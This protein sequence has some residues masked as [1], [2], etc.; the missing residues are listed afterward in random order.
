MLLLAKILKSLINKNYVFYLLS[1]YFSTL[2]ELI[3][4]FNFNPINT[5]E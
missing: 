2:K 1:F 4:I 3:I 5:I